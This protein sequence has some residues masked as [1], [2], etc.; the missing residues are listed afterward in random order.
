[1]NM[2]R[3]NA[4]K[5]GCRALKMARTRMRSAAEAWQSSLKRDCI[6]TD[7]TGLNG[8]HMG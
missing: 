7:A 1:M 4:L 3:R 8:S 6:N 2:S 5:M